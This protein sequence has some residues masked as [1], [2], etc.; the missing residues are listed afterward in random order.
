[1]IGAVSIEQRASG[2]RDE[3]DNPPLIHSSLA[4]IVV[5]H[6]EASGQGETDGRESEVSSTSALLIRVLE[7]VPIRSRQPGV[8]RG[9]SGTG[10]F[11]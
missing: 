2:R 7:V 3:T 1:M 8:R 5:D 10:V 4:H 9:E 11:T 6:E